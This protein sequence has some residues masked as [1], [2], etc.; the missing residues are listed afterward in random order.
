M[1]V[2][3]IKVAEK[4]YEVEIEE[5]KEVSG[6]IDTTQTTKSEGKVNS[7]DGSGVT[8]KAPLQASVFNINVSV[9]DKVKKGDVLMILEAMKLE[10]EILS[11]IDG[12]IKQVKVSKSESVDTGDVLVVIG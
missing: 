4:L 7:G 1:K 8:V 6:S 2:Y 11:P 3:K 10:N 5:I 12:T 9:G